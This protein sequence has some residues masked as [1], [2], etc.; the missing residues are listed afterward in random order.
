MAEAVNPIEYSRG[1]CRFPASTGNPGEGHRFLCKAGDPHKGLVLQ[2]CL[3]GGWPL[4]R[5]GTCNGVVGS[6]GKKELP[7]V[8]SQSGW[9]NSRSLWLHASLIV[10]SQG[11]QR[12]PTPYVLSAFENLYQTNYSASAR[13]APAS[14][15]LTFPSKV[16]STPLPF[17]V[18]RSDFPVFFL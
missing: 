15:K 14:L 17:L 4:R 13:P 9:G 10:A 6:R 1:S 7:A 16:T 2:H 3:S 11:R 8:Q 5:L 18:T 12:L